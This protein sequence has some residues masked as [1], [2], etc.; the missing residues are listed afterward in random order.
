MFF[1]KQSG[2]NSK[3]TVQK[4]LLLKGFISQVYGSNKWNLKIPTLETFISLFPFFLLKAQFV[5]QFLK[6]SGKNI[7]RA[8]YYTYKKMSMK[9]ASRLQ[10]PFLK[11]VWCLILNVYL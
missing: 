3:R 1:S 9:M 7:G 2:S 10:K 8:S 6:K 4:S 11:P 5:S